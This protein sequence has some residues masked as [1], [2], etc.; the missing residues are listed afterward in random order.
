MFRRVIKHHVHFYFEFHFGLFETETSCT[1][2]HQSPS[3][4]LP[5]DPSEWQKIQ[6]INPTK[7]KLPFRA[8]PEIKLNE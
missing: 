6:N 8:Q 2:H 4:I 5:R 7:D 3:V 1:D